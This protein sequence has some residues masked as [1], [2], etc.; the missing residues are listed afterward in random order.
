VIGALRNKLGE[1]FIADVYAKWQ[2]RGGEALERMIDTDPGGFVRVVAQVLPDKLEVDVKHTVSRIERVIVNRQLGRRLR[3]RGDIG[4]G[5]G[6]AVIGAPTRYSRR[7]EG[8]RLNAL[9]FGAPAAGGSGASATPFLNPR[10]QW[11]RFP[12]ASPG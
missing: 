12:P 6:V 3:P 2:A 9:T 8:S 4:A 11:R 10:R 7:R 1:A 5:P